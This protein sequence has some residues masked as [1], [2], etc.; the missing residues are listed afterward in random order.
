LFLSICIRP[1]YSSNQIKTCKIP[2]PP[3]IFRIHKKQWTKFFCKSIAYFWCF[4]KQMIKS[5]RSWIDN[6]MPSWTPSFTGL[7]NSFRVILVWDTGL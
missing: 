6:L 2:P 4:G 3:K 5:Y 7:Y 1:V